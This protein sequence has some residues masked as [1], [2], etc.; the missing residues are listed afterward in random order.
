MAR[1]EARISV[2]IWSDGDFIALSP[3]A[4]RTFF[5]LVSQVDLA[6]DGVL[7]L[8]ERRWARGA[9]GLTA[10]VVRAELAE[11]EAARFV[12]IDEDAEELL[13]RSFIRRDKVYRQPNVFRAAADHLPLVSSPKVRQAIGEELRRIE[14]EPMPDGSV[15]IVAE[16]LAAIGG[17]SP[18]PSG[19]PSGKGSDIPPANPTPGAPG[20][21]GGVIPLPKDNPPISPAPVPRSTSKHLSGQPALDGTPEPT[22]LEPRR[23]ATADFD[24]F[25]SAYPRRDNKANALKAWHKA[26]KKAP[27][28]AIIAAAERFRDWPGR[29]PQFTA[30]GSTWLN[31]ERWNDELDPNAGRPTPTRQHQPYMNPQDPS[32]YEGAL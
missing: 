23:T 4:Q 8:R 19:D 28:E 2:D 17:P 5:F 31:G 9:A 1:S 32:I 6:H 25:W 7:A 18:N 15:A 13:V 29:T 22:Q 3:G 10:D 24:R 26:V 12:V 21:R 16:M 30:H 20:E 11:L 27:A 14:N